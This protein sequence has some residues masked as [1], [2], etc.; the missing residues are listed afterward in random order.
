M[1]K[2]PQTNISCLYA[3]ARAYIVVFIY[4]LLP[5]VILIGISGCTP[6]FAN[7]PTPEEFPPPIP[8]DT[9]TPTI[10]WFPPTPTYTPFPTMVV[11]PTVDIRPQV[12]EILF[13]DNFRD[14]SLWTLAESATSSVALGQNEV[15]LALSQPG[16]Y[17]FSLRQNPILSDFYLEITAM[18]SIC[19]GKDEYGILFRVSPSLD[20]YRFSLSCDGYI[21]LDRFV[22]GRASSPYP[23]TISGAVPPGAPSF[24]LIGVWARGKEMHFYVNDEYQFTIRDPSIT[25]GSIGVFARSVGENAVTVSFSDLVVHSVTE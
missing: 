1:R 7:D 14:G 5:L 18:P 3:K 10:V 24:S 23:S 17:I 15:T 8:S 11:T 2:N 16:A 19:Q 12:G 21:R 9:T 22:N 25:S 4:I 20:F 6:V 13:T